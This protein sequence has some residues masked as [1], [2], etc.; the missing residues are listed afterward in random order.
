[1]ISFFDASGELFLANLTRIQ[2]ANEDVQRQISSGFK[3]SAPQDAPDQVSLILQLQAQAAANTRTEANLQ[4]AKSSVN[5]ADGALT[6]ALK[7]IDD[8][9]SAGAEA[10]SVSANASSRQIL[11]GRVQSILEHAVSISQMQAGGRY[12][13][14]GDLYQ[15]PTYA[16]NLA[17]SNG[18]TRI[19]VPTNSLS[20]QDSNGNSIQ[21]TLT[22]NEIFDHRNPDDS[23]ASDNL[24]ASLT[25]L[26]NG[27]NADDTDAISAAVASLKSAGSWINQKQG[28]YGAAQNR[29]DSAIAT[30]QSLSTSLKTRLSELRETDFVEAALAL[31]TGQTQLQAAMSARAKVPQT[32]L[33]DFLG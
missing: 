17:N 28:F 18:V 15:S 1:M 29:L 9:S 22:A 26:I 31:T 5:L 23:Y 27:L 21:T 20:V 25:N 14:S 3:V 2:E 10:L 32:S 11:A 13:F 8:A 12:I 24:F 19:Q 33:F 6:D 4:Q 7:L 30:S 16:V